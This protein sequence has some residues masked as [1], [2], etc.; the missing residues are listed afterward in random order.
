MYIYVYIYIYIYMYKD[1]NSISITLSTIEYEKLFIGRKVVDIE[2][3]VQ[4]HL[5][6]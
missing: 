3:E 2:E 5:L 4:G 1:E 6:Y